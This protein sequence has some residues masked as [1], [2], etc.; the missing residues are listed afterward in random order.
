MTGDIKINTTAPIQIMTC[1]IY[2]NQTLQ[3][4][5]NPRNIA[6]VIFD[7]AHYL[8]DKERGN[9]WENSII[10]T[11]PNDIQILCLSATI[12]NITV[13]AKWLSENTNKKYNYISSIYLR[14]INY[15][16]VDDYGL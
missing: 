8:G 4:S 2:N 14:L 3:L 13:A 1:E 5:K 6:T 11:P 9:V 16:M 7:E 10:N 15:F 12:G